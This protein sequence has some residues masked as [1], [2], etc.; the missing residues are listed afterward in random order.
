MFSSLRNKKPV[1][2]APPKKYMLI[3]LIL[4]AIN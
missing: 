4:C 3:A 1:I 2:E